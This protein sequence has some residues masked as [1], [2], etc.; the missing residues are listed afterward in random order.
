MAGTVKCKPPFTISI[1]KVMYGI[2]FTTQGSALL[3]P[4][5]EGKSVN[6]KFTETKFFK[7]LTNTCI[8]EDPQQV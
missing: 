4:V 6:A 5:P 8:N 7:K 2:V 3:N 1:K